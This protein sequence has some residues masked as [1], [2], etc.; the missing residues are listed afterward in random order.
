MVEGIFNLRKSES[1][2][3]IDT[4]LTNTTPEGNWKDKY[5]DNKQKNNT[6]KRD[7]QLNREKSS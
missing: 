3:T 7:G 2:V 6:T 5:K 4:W 1:T